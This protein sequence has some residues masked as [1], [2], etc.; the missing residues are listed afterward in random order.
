MEREPDRL[1]ADLPEHG[2]DAAP[3]M[4]DSRKTRCGLNNAVD[5]GLAVFI[6]NLEAVKKRG[7]VGFVKI[8]IL[9][10]IGAFDG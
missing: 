2:F 9:I 4:P 5:G 6:G 10:L 7:L 3:G 8:F 1:S